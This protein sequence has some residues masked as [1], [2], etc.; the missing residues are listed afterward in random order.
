MA[1]FDDSSPDPGDGDSGTLP[2]RDRMPDYAAVFG[3]GLAACVGVGGVIWMISDVALA[4]SVGYT[5][6]LYGVVLMLAGGATGGG[7]TN[8]GMGAVGAL[9]GTRRADE[10][11]EEVG[12]TWS[13]GAKID[14]KER[15]E[16]GLRPDAN[17]RAFWQVIGGIAYV[18]LGLSVVV[19]FS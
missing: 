3:V 17:P 1:A 15:L 7:Y 4:S 10:T 9:F 19:L 16:R 18:T 5:V 2:L 13:D 11:Q 6:I 12:R 14:P 8:L